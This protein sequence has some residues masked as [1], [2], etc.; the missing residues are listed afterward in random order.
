MGSG[1][2]HDERG[3][4]GA[5]DAEARAF[6]AAFRSFLDWVHSDQNDA[7]TRNEVVALIEDFLAAARPQHSV[8]TRPL[9]VFEHVSLQTAIDAWSTEPGRTVSMHGI[10]IPPHHG[11]V[12]LQQ[13]VTGEGIPRLR[14][15]APP[16]VDLPNGPGSTLACV[17]LAAL[18]VTDD[19]GKY[20]VMIVGPSEHE[21]GLALEV[22]GLSVGAAQAVH[23]ELD[24]LRSRLNVYRGHVLDVSV[25]PMGGVALAFGEVPSTAREDVVLPEIVLSRV[26][27][28]ALGVSA[29]RDALLEAGQHLKRGL[30]LY[31]RPVPVEHTPPG[32]S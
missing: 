11:S 10:T 16:L 29:H 15:S 9:P 3:M 20:V 32:T 14:L 7:Y 1:G 19:R 6:A 24:D 2:S 21:Q 18:L 8:V 5:S 25:T 28:H 31:G 13:L 4:T 12:R 27:R 26:E 17:L 23:A 22:A 30:L